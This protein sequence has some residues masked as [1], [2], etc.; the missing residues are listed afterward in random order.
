MTPAVEFYH[1]GKVPTAT[2]QQRQHTAAGKSYLPAGAAR[3]RA[4]WL[5]VAEKYRHLCPESLRGPLEF[6]LSI[7]WDDSDLKWKDTAPDCDN[8]SKLALDAF[9]KTGY[10]HRG[11]QQVARLIVEKR[12]GPIPGI[13]VQITALVDSTQNVGV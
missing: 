3:A 2:A 7:M 4:W 1:E 13:V 8:L 9:A 6:R 5:A 11:D 12:W 10:F